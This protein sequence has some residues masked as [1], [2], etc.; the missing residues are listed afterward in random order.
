VNDHSTAPVIAEHGAAELPAVV[1]DSYNVEIKDGDKFIG[2]NASTRAFREILDQWR[3]AARKDGDDPLGDEPSSDISKKKLDKIIAG[4]DVEAAG[5]VLATVEEFAQALSSV[6]ARFMKQKDW[7]NTERIVFG[8][9]LRGSRVGELAISRAALLLKSQGMDIELCPIVH[10]PDEAG[11]IGAAHLAPSWL[12]A[13]HDAILAV[14]IGGTNMRT[15]VVRLKQKKGK[16]ADL[17]DAEVIRSELWRHRDD[18]PSREEA[19]ARLVD[20]LEGLIAWVA[21]EKIKVAPFIGIG[22]PG[23]VTVEGSI[24]RG[25]Q[26]LPGNWESSRFHLPRLLREAIPEIAGHQTAIVMHN[27]AVV[28]GLSEVPRMQDVER[29]AVLTMGTGLGNAR[30]SNRRRDS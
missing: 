12:F 16:S 22:V 21:K 10:D 9:G 8:G 4:D 1:V 3:K 25:A 13:G 20:M 27:D 18:K 28:Q 15:G 5:V 30:F 24:E 19:V 23:I 2:D 6:I 11:L 14:D 26:N 7:K 29:W 17:F